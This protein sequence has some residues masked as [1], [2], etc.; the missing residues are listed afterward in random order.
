MIQIFFVEMDHSLHSSRY[1][2]LY[3]MLPPETKKIIDLFHF[4]ANRRIRIASEILLRCQICRS[5]GL[6]AAD[7]QFGRQ[8]F[9]KPYLISE[10]AFHFNVSHSG[11]GVA[12]GVSDVPIGVDTE[13]IRKEDRRVARRIFTDREYDW[14]Y[15][16]PEQE[17]LRFF[18][19]W[20]KKEAYMKWT[21]SGFAMKTKSFDVLDPLTNGHISSI[22]INQYWISAYASHMHGNIDITRISE[23]ELYDMAIYFMQ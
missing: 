22:Q 6:R 11:N 12:L 14:V 5:T 23:D 18:E 21:G 19:I 2:S 4:E 3:S 17:D 1:D 8:E 15:A 16:S 7:L 13:Q 10:P 9:G 20:T